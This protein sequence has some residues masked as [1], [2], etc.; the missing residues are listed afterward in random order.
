MEEEC[1]NSILHTC[2]VY[3]GRG[4]IKNQILLIISLIQFKEYL[5]N[6]LDKECCQNT[7][8]IKEGN[9]KKKGTFSFVFP[10]IIDNLLLILQKSF[11]HGKVLTAQ[12]VSNNCSEQSQLH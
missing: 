6:G 1:E 4:V 3:T 5:V 9:M 7:Y 10:L 2:I 12:D 8:C 11:E